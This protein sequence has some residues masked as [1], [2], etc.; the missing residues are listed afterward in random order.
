MSAA[1]LGES[2]FPDLRK[3][4]RSPYAARLSALEVGGTFRAPMRHRARLS[5]LATVWGRKLGRK[6]RT[7]KLGK[8]Y[9]LVGRVA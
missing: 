9:C 2:A 1:P 5:V 8:T 6:F 7:S 3:R 4:P